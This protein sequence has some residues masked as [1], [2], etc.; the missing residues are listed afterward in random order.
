MAACG[1]STPDQPEVLEYPTTEMAEH[2]D[3]YHG[4]D[5]ADPYRWLEDDVR[6]SAAVADWIN[7]Q[8]DVTAAYL[9]SIPERDIIKERLTE[10][11]DHERYGQPVKEGG[12][13]YYS[14]NSGL[15]N[16]SVIYV[17]EHL[18][19]EAKVLMD[20]NTW[21]DDGTVAL[22]SY[23]PSPDGSHV[24]YLVQDGGSDWRK[25]RV[26]EVDTRKVL[27]DE[28]SWLKF[29]G[30]SW[31]RD[32]SGFYYS[33]Y[34]ATSDDTKF[35]SLNL[36][37]A[38]YFHRLGTPQDEDALVY[39]RPENPEWGY[40]ATVTDDGAHLVIA[41]WKG[42]DSRYQ[43]VH[44]DLTDTAAKAELLIEGI[45]YDYS[46]VGNIG[47]KLYFRTNNGA[48]RNRLITIDVDEPDPDSWHEVIP[49]AEDVLDGVGS[50]AS[51]VPGS[52][53]VSSSPTSKV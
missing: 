18:D 15:Q 1:R 37:Q 36:N 23:A 11:W 43:I 5:V 16:Q 21:S 13:Y 7:A 34:P 45:D 2:I 49:E 12:R 35:Q 26:I 33:R 42:T 3:S 39:R 10:L 30:L 52:R 8:N 41:T 27:E 25:A 38:V 28:L 47:S 4:T 19:A 50:K 53:L 20:P 31:A 9:E 40:S 48:P 51:N 24:A 46:L 32:G 29:T 14:H 17:Q 22:A 44:Q 6:E